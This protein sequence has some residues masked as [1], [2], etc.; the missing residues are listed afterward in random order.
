MPASRDP[1]QLQLAIKGRQLAVTL[2]NASNQDIRLWE[3]HNSWGWYALRF[4][5]VL[6]DD[7]RFEIKRRTREWTKN[8]PDYFALAPH[9]TRAVV[10]DL[11]DGWWAVDTLD[12]AGGTPEDWRARPMQMRACLRIPPTPE[13]E[14]LGVFTGAAC[15][16]WTASRPPNDWLVLSRD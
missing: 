8:G 6:D 11:D 14:R 3:W 7:R 16:E 15:S 2:S 10:I 13:S 4:E 9:E 12:A 5:V 1:L